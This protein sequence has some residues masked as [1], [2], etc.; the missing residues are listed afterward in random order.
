MS[1]TEYLDV[2]MSHLA[3]EFSLELAL[4]LIEFIQFKSYLEMNMNIH[5][6]D[7]NTISFCSMRLCEDIPKSSIVY[8]TA[9]DHKWKARELYNKYI[10]IGSNY[11][12]NVHSEIRA[13][14]AMMFEKSTI[15]PRFG[16]RSRR[17]NTDNIEIDVEE[18]SESAISPSIFVRCADEMGRLLGFSLTRFKT[19]PDYVKLLNFKT[20]MVIMYKE[21]H[22]HVCK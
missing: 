19:K 17:R 20:K 13:E 14:L 11:E 22:T 8:D 16:S 12:I 2:F 5:L 10:R 7:G 1:K 4:S 9:H 21:S 18:D 6:D 3:Q 15:R